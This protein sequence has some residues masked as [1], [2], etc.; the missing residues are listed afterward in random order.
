MDWLKTTFLHL[1]QGVPKVKWE[2]E[3]DSRKQWQQA[4]EPKLHF[5]QGYPRRYFN[6][7]LSISTEFDS[8]IPIAVELEMVQRY[9][10]EDVKKQ[11]HHTLEIMMER[12]KSRGFK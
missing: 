1:A 9:P 3:R 2:R 8:Q 7:P 6:V 4:F 12:Y 5:E 10:W 11:A